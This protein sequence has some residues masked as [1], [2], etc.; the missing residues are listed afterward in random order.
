MRGSDDDKDGCLAQF[1]PAEPVN[2][3]GIQDGEAFHRS[4]PE[5]FQ[6]LGSHC[7]VGVVFKGD[8][9]TTVAG[10]SADRAGESRQSARVVFSEL[11]HEF[12]FV[13]DVAR[14]TGP[15]VR[16]A[17]GDGRDDGDLVAFF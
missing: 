17:A 14:K 3:D 8:E 16:G 7:V 1:Q 5:G 10:F 13:D 11:R 9:S 6:L 15:R 12:R 2:D 4:L